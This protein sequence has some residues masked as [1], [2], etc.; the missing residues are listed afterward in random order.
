MRSQLQNLFVFTAVFGWRTNGLE[1]RSTV[2]WRG[3]SQSLEV[4]AIFAY[5]ED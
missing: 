3:L 5:G 2:C 4:H 1:A